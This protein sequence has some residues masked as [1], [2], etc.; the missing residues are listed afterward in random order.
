MGILWI[1]LIQL[2]PALLFV[3]AI[4]WLLRRAV[5]AHAPQLAELEGWKRRRKEL[6]A[7]M[8]RE[9]YKL[10]NFERVT[11]LKAELEAHEILKPE[12]PGWMF[13]VR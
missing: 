1:L 12:L 9:S 11:M 10:E 7:E 5:Q 4:G 2:A 6:A 8:A 13:W 3:A